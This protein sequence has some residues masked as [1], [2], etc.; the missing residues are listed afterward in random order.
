[1]CINEI[2]NTF[3]YKQLKWC[4]DF[5]SRNNQKAVRT[6]FYEAIKEAINFT[7]LNHFVSFDDADVEVVIEVFRDVL[8]FAC[9][10][11]YKAKHKRYNMQAL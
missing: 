9:L 5:K 4:L 11:G 10:P 8:V 1:M 3:S 7:N 6:D 2:T